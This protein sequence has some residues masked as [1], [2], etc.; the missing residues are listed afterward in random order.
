MIGADP[1]ALDLT[2][3]GFA[4]VALFAG[5]L[6]LTAAAQGRIAAAAMAIV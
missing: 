4:T 5:E 2:C 1:V 6:V 3:T